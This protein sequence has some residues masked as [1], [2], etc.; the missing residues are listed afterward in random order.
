MPGVRLRQRARE[1]CLLESV[2]RRSACV[3]EQR[4]AVGPH[5]SERLQESFAEQGKGS[6]AC[7]MAEG[8]E[9]DRLPAEKCL[10]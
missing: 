10:R 6:G 5:F 9:S 8:A 4:L 1:G 3:R 2:C 7:A